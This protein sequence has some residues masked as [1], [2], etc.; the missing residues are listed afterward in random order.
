[1]YLG[2]DAMALAKLTTKVIY[3]EEGDWAI[4]TP[5]TY[6]IYDRNDNRVTR[7]ITII[8][9]GPAMAEKG[10]YRHFMLKEIHEQPET[11]GR[12]LGIYINDL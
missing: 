4:L 6:E 12:T 3:L 11:I 2:S 7:E 10:N 5:K 8:S 9:G 1:M